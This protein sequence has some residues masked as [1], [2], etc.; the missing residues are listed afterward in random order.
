MQWSCEPHAGFCSNCAPWLPIAH[1]YCSA[2]LNVD[3]QSG[4]ASSM[5]QVFKATIRIRRRSPALVHGEQHI[6]HTDDGTGLFAYRRSDV[7]P[8]VVVAMN[9]GEAAIEADLTYG[10]SGTGYAVLSTAE[11]EVQH[12][13]LSTCERSRL[14]GEGVLLF[15]GEII[16][17]YGKLCNLR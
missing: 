17:A 16:S 12:P 9:W 3:A 6:F 11:G 1:D 4:N 15:S 7:R 10:F 13:V 8:D 5:L 14:P 2:G